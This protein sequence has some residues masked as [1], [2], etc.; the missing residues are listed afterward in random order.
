M[1]GLHYIGDESIKGQGNLLGE[2]PTSTTE[3][4][5][6]LTHEQRTLLDLSQR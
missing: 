2:A 4:V 6:E 1:A 5:V 3:Q